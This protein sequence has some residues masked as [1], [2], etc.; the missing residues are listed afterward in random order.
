MT[1]LNAQ[2]QELT[3]NEVRG[4]VMSLYTWLAAGMPALGGWLLGTLMGVFPAQV[5]LV[6]GGIT[7]V[8]VTLVVSLR[9]HPE[10]RW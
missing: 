10:R 6:T 7:L 5:V 1:L 9:P 8:G 2:L 4:R 3:P